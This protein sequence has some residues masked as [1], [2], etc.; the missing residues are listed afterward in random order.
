VHYNVRRN[1]CNSLRI[2][3]S[4][5]HISVTKTEE[6]L[7]LNGRQSELVQASW[8]IQSGQS[9]TSRPEQNSAR[10]AVTNCV[11]PKG[12]RIVG[13]NESEGLK[14]RNRTQLHWAT[15]V[16]RLAGSIQD[17]VPMETA[18]AALGY[19]DV[20]HD[21]QLGQLH[22]GAGGSIPI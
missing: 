16:R 13:H 22:Y 5:C 12:R 7:L 11:E 2:E 15:G 4:R 10:R 17:I 9:P 1:F 3:I 14:L 18:L 8:I 6:D 20:R 19:I 21:F